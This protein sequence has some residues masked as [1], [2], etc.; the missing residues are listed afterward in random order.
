[1]AAFQLASPEYTAALTGVKNE[2]MQLRRVAGHLRV[3]PGLTRKLFAL[4]IEIE[5][6][7]HE[8]DSA[9]NLEV[10]AASLLK[11]ARRIPPGPARRG[12]LKQVGKLRIRLDA[13]VSEQKKLSPCPAGDRSHEV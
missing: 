4:A 5:R 6:L 8:I 7:A 9:E 1:M 2:V 12:V 3:S 13:L 10:E 11:T